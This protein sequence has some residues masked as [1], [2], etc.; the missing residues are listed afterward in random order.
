MYYSCFYCCWLLLFPLMRLLFCFIFVL[1]FYFCFPSPLGHQLCVTTWSELVII[2][3][4]TLGLV[5]THLQALGVSLLKPSFLSLFLIEFCVVWFVSQVSSFFKKVQVTES[6]CTFYPHRLFWCSVDFFAN[7]EV[8]WTKRVGSG[9]KSN[10]FSGS[11]TKQP[12]H[13]GLSPEKSRCVEKTN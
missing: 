1:L 10:I 3:W 6:S 9:I 12:T 8:K 13:V 7:L 2:D 5:V 11:E 4:S